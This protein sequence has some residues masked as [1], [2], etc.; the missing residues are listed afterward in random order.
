MKTRIQLLG[1]AVIAIV[2]ATSATRAFAWGLSNVSS[3]VDKASTASDKVD[4][5]KDT[6]ARPDAA[7]QKQAGVYGT[8]N[9][10]KTTVNDTK[11]NVN[12]VSNAA[13]D[14]AG[15][16][17]GQRSP[18]RVFAVNSGSKSGQAYRQLTSFFTAANAAWV[19][20]DLVGSKYLLFKIYLKA[21]R[22]L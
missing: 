9:E 2:S 20:S 13:T 19:K 3:T 12:A 4:T 18:A 8:V 1:F 15:R 14:S 6:A 7:V 10:A 17:H 5:A 11:S 21:R 16:D 22:L